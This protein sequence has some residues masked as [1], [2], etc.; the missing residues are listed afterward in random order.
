MKHYLKA[1]LSASALLVATQAHATDYVIDPDTTHT[2]APFYVQSASSTLIT[3][4]INGITPAGT[5]A[6]T[7]FTDTFLFLL[8]FLANGTGSV[9]SSN[10][11]ALTFTDAFLTIYSDAA[12]TNQIGFFQG[13]VG[14][15]GFS[16]SAAVTGGGIP[17][18]T[19]DVV[20]VKG[21]SYGG[22]YG[23]VLRADAIPAVPEPATWA[24]LLAGF[25][26]V[27]FAMRR[28]REQNVRVSFG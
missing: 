9:T 21:V 10:F 1:A 22:N 4:A 14:T 7:S 18:N 12:L 11:T 28:R 8:P 23:G 2:G 24:M 6:G 16:I 17:A 27:G 19:F 15:L 5:P 13:S 25:G 3:A 26:A 20:T